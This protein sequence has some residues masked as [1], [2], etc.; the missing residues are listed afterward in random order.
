MFAT[1]VA[2][3]GLDFPNVDWVLQVDAPEDPDMYVH[4]VGR[5]ARFKQQ[6]QALMLLD[7]SEEEYIQK[8]KLKAPLHKKSI[9]PTKTM[10]VSQRAASLV[11]EHASLHPL[12]KKSFLS[13]VRSVA[14]LPKSVWPDRNV[15]KMNLEAYA[16]SLGLAAMPNLD[17]LEKVT[18]REGLRETKNVN[19]KLQKLK[20]QIRL[21]KEQ[22][23][24]KKKQTNDED[25][26]KRK[27]G[28]ADED[29]EEDDLLVVK[30]RHEYDANIDVELAT[31]SHRHP[32]R[33][34][35]DGTNS[36]KSQ[37]KVFEEDGT[38][39]PKLL[40]DTTNDDDEAVDTEALQDANDSYME[41]VRQRLEQ[42]RDLDKQEERERIR[43]KHKKKRLQEKTERA[44][45]EGGVE[46][47]QPP[48]AVL[49]PMEDES[50]SDDDGSSSGSDSESVASSSIDEDVDVA[51]QEDLALSLIRGQS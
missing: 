34:R 33:I 5:T 9:N 50:E 42:T 44:E 24:L 47:Q 25:S 26:K 23:K 38:E 11:A 27:S 7:P 31:D 36:A 18:N 17:F 2:S 51:A 6:G 13:F 43:A 8:W 28:S 10:L 22:K 14:L 37:H 48:M 29:E 12:A 49:E 4:R 1:D 16:L 30:A 21:E 32:K 3:R 45:E 15:Q 20:E 35:I 19:R 41:K 46:R 40:Q 39:K